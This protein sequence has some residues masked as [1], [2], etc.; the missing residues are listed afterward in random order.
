MP[1]KKFGATILNQAAEVVIN[2]AEVDML[3]SE[4]VE[5][6]KAVVSKAKAEGLKPVPDGQGGVM[7]VPKKSN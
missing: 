4:Q 6:V 3:K 5:Q 7:F 2:Y 1:E